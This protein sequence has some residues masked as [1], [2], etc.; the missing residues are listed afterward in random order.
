MDGT[1]LVLTYDEA[2]D[3][4]SEPAASSYSVSVDS[5]TGAAPSSVEVSGMTVTL[6]LGTTSPSITNPP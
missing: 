2:L 6:T 5:G 3:A 4:S 1:S